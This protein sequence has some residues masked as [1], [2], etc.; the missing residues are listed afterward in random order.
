[1][2]SPERTRDHESPER[3]EAARRSPEGR[4]PPSRRTEPRPPDDPRAGGDPDRRRPRPVRG[5][6]RARGAG[7]PRA[8]RLRAEAARG[9]GRPLQPQP[10]R[11]RARDRQRRACFE[12]PRRSVLRGHRVDSSHEG[13]GDPLHADPDDGPRRRTRPPRD[14]E[15]GSLHRQA[16]R[17]AALAARGRGADAR[18]AAGRPRHDPRARPA[19]AV[20][21]PIPGRGGAVAKAARHGLV[22]RPLRRPLGR[23]ARAGDGVARAAATSS[24]C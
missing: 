11:A 24:R 19:S 2:A 4:A 5:G 12:C 20:G 13:P 6:A 1:M 23:G 21:D 14:P 17:P 22:V 7:V 16:R 8:P 10:V 9:R 18:D 3:G 15:T